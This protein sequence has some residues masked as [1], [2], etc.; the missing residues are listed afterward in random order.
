MVAKSVEVKA[1]S[2][3]DCWVNQKVVE[4]VVYWAAMMAESLAVTRVVRSVSK[5]VDW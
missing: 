3:G 1:A 2:K 4:M 5:L